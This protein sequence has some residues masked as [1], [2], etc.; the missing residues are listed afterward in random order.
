[1]TRRE[2]VDEVLGW[3]ARRRVED[4]LMPGYV[5]RTLHEGRP[6]FNPWNTA[7]YLATD[8][9]YVRIA[10]RGASGVLHLSR[11]ASFDGARNDVEA[12]IDREA[13]E[14]FMPASLESRFL[15]DGRDAHTLSGARYVHGA[16]SRPEEGTVDCLEL[17]FDGHGCLFVSP[18]WDG[19]LIGAHGSYEHWTG[20]LHAEDMGS[21][22][23]VRWTPPAA[24]EE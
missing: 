15:A 7:L 19:L 14:E 23:E 21:R 22:K 13:G 24:D 5:D 6:F 4:V 12:F 9:E 17:A 16:H 8:R 2:S 1:M 20:H 10:D 3:L 18:E 11:T